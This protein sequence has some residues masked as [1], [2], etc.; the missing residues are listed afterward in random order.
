M[1]QAHDAIVVGASLAGCT[2]AT[3]MARAGARVA[4][5]EKHADPAAFKRVCGHFL[6][7]GAVPVLERL[8]VLDE[9]LAAGAQR[10][11]P[12]VWTR[13]GWSAAPPPDAARETLNLRRAVLDPIVRRTTAATPGVTL[14]AGHTVTAARAGRDGARVTARA[15]TGGEVELRGRLLVGADGRSSKVAELLGV[16]TR[17]SRNDRFGYWGYFEGPGL[18]TGASV[19]IWFL[20]PD[21]G[22]VTPTDGGLTQYVAFPVAERAAAFKRDPEGELRAFIAAL[23][24]APPIGACTRVGPMVGKLDLTNEWRRA[25]GD[26]WALTGDAALAADP[27]G[28]IGCGWALQSGEWLADAAGR[29]LAAGRPLGAALRRYRRRHRRELLGHS[30]LAAD[31]ARA[32]TM[33]P[34]QRL[35]FSAAQDDPVTGDR[36]ELFAARLARPGSL[37]SPRS[38]GRAAFVVARR[39][40]P[41]RP[42][43]PRAARPAAR[44][45][46]RAAA[47]RSRGS[48]RG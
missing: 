44:P 35:L 23:P 34:V 41:M 40:A 5:V 46:V 38:L 39:R 27:V 36:L 2:A 22:I 33:S 14:L 47:A 1:A 11:R 48:A 20:E 25:A 30:L 45:P 3:L 16:R 10:G 26:G 7:P 31:G 21:V 32:G 37:L 24:D 42:A 28:A 12:R 18:D 43:R 19:H 8:G 17:R 9:V 6:Q 4:L 15:R 13:Y 29:A